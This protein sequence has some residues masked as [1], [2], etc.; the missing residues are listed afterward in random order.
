MAEVA[1]ATAQRR[2]GNTAQAAPRTGLRAKTNPPG[3]FSR[4]TGVFFGLPGTGKT[5][6]TTSIPKTL[7]VEFDPDGDV[8]K[9]LK[10]RT[11]VDVFK[12]TTWQD[13]DEVIHAL[14]GPDRD[15]WD[16]VALDSVTFW[17]EML[18]GKQLAETLKAN[19][20]PR[21]VYQKAGT[22]INQAIRDLMLF[23]G[24]VLFT[25][26]L[27]AEGSEEDV[28]PLEDD[29]TYNVSLAITPMVFKVLTPAVSVIGR[30][31]KKSGNKGSQYMVSF[32]DGGRT[33]V[34]DRYGLPTQIENLDLG[35]LVSELRKRG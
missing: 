27:K 13:M 17:F 26:Q 33:P 10:G 35:K 4:L 1:T 7:L 3:S 9:S 22:N 21:P 11:D 12:P 28:V 20:D 18:G 6:V 23:P 16:A 5:T 31:F 30:T 25:A 34:K 8:T 15:T 24:H 29:G 32:D 14:L 2:R 19:R